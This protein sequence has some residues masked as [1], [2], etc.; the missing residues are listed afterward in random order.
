[1]QRLVEVYILH[2][3]SKCNERQHKFGVSGKQ[4]ISSAGAQQTHR[5]EGQ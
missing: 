4:N 1:M 3:I 5:V 2:L